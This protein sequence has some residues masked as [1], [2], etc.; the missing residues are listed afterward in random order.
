MSEVVYLKEDRWIPFPNTKY[1]IQFVFFFL[2]EPPPPEFSPFP[3]PAPLP[4][5]RAPPPPPRAD[6]APPALPRK[7]PPRPVE[8]PAVR[9]GAD[10]GELQAVRR[11]GPGGEAT[12]LGGVFL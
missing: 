10:E 11:H 2:N 8:T 9:A 7:D 3:Q 1:P 6:P 4:F 12:V 5:W